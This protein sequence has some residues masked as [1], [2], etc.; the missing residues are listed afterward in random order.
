MDEVSSLRGRILYQRGTGNC[1]ISDYAL[2]GDRQVSALV[3]RGGSIDWWC[4][5]R[6]DAPSAFAALLNPSAGHWSIRP[7]QGFR[8]N[9]RYLPDTMVVQTEFT[10]DT[11]TLR[12][13]DALALGR[14]ER[15]HDIGLRSPHVLIR[16]VEVLDGEVAVA[17]ELV[18]RP[19]YGLVHPQIRRAP[20]GIELVGGSDRFLLTGDVDWH[21]RET[22]LSASL[23]MAAGE[24]VR[25]GPARRQPDRELPPVPVPHR[26]DRGLGHRPGGGEELNHGTAA[27]QGGLDNGV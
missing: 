7:L 8:V 4:P 11:G 10:T 14:G 21:V 12:L 20:A 18:A 23:L 25:C 9:R 2:L 17:V 19:E 15:G 24:S 3:S 26:I 27:R 1:R 5:T 6:F 13:T 16:Q 22:S